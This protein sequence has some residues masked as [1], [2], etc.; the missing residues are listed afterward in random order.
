MDFVFVERPAQRLWGL[1]WE[2]TYD[3]A[4]AKGVHGVFRAMTEAR[5]G[6][7]VATDA[8][9]IGIAWNDRPDGFRYLV[10]VAVDE[11]AGP[12]PAWLTEVRLPAMRLAS[13][14]HDAGE[15]T[16]A[17]FAMFDWIARQGMRRDVSVADHREEYPHDFDLAAGVPLRLM[18]PVAEQPV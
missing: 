11:T 13:L 5:K 7:P 12:V 3:E 4:A 10:A 15:P 17:Y 18:T 2:G 6:L 8:D 1:V 16:Q 14:W 9:L